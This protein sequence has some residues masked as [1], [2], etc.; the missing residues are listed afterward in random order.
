[1]KTRNLLPGLTFLW[2]AVFLPGQSTFANSTNYSDDVKRS[3]TS[4]EESNTKT[5][6]WDF[7]A[8]K[9]DTNIYI[10]NLTEDI[11]NSWYDESIPVGS[12]GNVLP[13]FTA[14]VLSWIG[15]GNDRLRSTNTN[16]TRYDDNI[17]SAENYTGRVYVNSSSNPD[18]Y[19]SLTLNEDDEVTLITKTD[20]GGNLNFEYVADPTAQTDEVVLTSD[21]TELKFVAKQAGNYHIYDDQGKPS[22]YRIYRKDAEYAS[23]TGLIDLTQA[24]G[25]PAEYAVQ[26]ENEAG[27]VW[28]SAM[29][30][31]EYN[32]QLPIGYTYQLSLSDANGY[33][34]S[35]ENTLEV[36]DTTTTFNL[37]IVQVELYTVSGTITGLDSEIS[38]LELVYTP[39]PVA[40]KIYIPAPEIDAV[41]GTYSVQLEPDCE[42]AI[43]AIGVNDFYIPVNTI[44]IG[45]ADETANVDFSSK[46]TSNITINTTGLT[47]EQL[48]AMSITFNNLHEEGYQYNFTSVEGITLRDGTYTLTFDG[49]DDY[50]VEIGLTSNL[51]VEGADK[52]KTLAFYPVKNW[53]FDDKEIANGT[54]SYKGL[55]FSGT[56]Y[57]ELAKGHISA[58][59]GATIQI[60]VNVSDKIRV[61][62]YYSA[63]FSID[64]SESFTTSSGSTGTLEYADYTYTGTKAGYATITIG[65]GAS[66]TY[67]TN[68]ELGAVVDFEPVIYVGPDKL[69][70][71]INSALEAIAKMQR[72][73]D[74]RV[75]V[76][77]DPGNYEEMLVIN[78]PN[79]TLKNASSAPD[80][81]L[82]NSGVDISEN[83][84]R[85]TSFYGHGYNYFSMENNQ[86]WNADRLRVN[87]ENGY[88][89]YENKGAGTTNGSY[90]NA[91]VVINTDGFEA[92]DIIFENSFNQYISQKESEDILVMWESGSKGER[93]TNYGNTD[94][95]NKS[96]VE[97]A[98]AIA[99]SSADKV[100]L[101]RC[102]VIGRQDSFFGGAGSRV[103]IYK[104]T[105]MGGTDYMFGAM[106][107]VFYKTKLAMNTSEDNNDVSYLTAAQQSSGRGYLMYECTITSAT[108]GTETTS[109]YRS[110]PGYFGRPW[111]ATTSEVVFFNTTIETT[112]FPGSEDK[113][114]ILSVGWN[115]SLGGESALMYEYGTIEESGVNNL[116]Y[117]ATWSTILTEPTLSDGT[118]ITTFNFTK[119]FDNWDPVPELISN[120][121]LEDNTNNVLNAPVE[122]PVKVYSDGNRIFISDVKAKTLF[123]IY[124]LNGSLIRTLETDTDTDFDFQN[125]LWLV[126]INSNEEQKTVKV[127]VQ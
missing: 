54:L 20:A 112:N 99:I 84:V 98:A 111:L 118:D 45:S 100:V 62:Y 29:S 81:V 85:I 34:I 89:S 15:G 92:E 74:E 57:N 21:V 108:P 82:A 33:I 70:Q 22:Y 19:M 38:N 103:V 116:P 64:G 88:L 8:E 60:P 58:K 125:G 101:N 41:A 76:M 23:I 114:L 18:R 16:L 9:L 105:M 35:T 87:K 78:V 94:V 113:S 65:S 28:T 96:F 4:I 86:K 50:P 67:I 115:S 1:M 36:T 27:K 102:R 26:F 75:V 97:R 42:Y 121:T 90:W 51:I 110:K 120:D 83:A 25:I 17:S 91:T 127:L 69:Y 61:T 72:D 14:G 104:G 56:V 49:L 66:T 124:S 122:S 53:S 5:E 37:S 10:N 119:G 59:P 40:N 48:S 6:V 79:V 117:R 43:S 7:G 95:Q 3:N 47:A 80:I 63:D 107:A 46:P 55:L 31:G 93:P 73:N 77:I 123:N 2:C 52:T 11:I 12:T 44:T 32:V 68:I 106:T 39:D 71:S 24:A 30:P 13:S 109:V 126:C